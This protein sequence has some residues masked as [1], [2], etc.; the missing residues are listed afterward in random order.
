MGYANDS[1]Y[2]PATIASIMDSLMA[3]LNTQFETAYTTDSFIGTNWYK[4][5]Y[6]AAQRIQQD[7]TKT[8]EI[9]ANLQ[10][11]FKITNERIQRPVATSPGI[12]E[13]L[14]DAGYIAS[15]KPIISADAGKMNICVSTDETAPTYA[16][17][18]L[19]INTLISESVAGGIVTV[20]TE[21]STIVLSNG[22]S[23]AFVFHLPNRITPK[24]RLT[25]TL[26]ENNQVLV[27]DPDD[28]KA[29]L[30]A[31]IAAKYRLGLDFAPQKYFTTVDAPWT[32]QV[33]LEYSLDGGSTYVSTIYTANFDDLFVIDLANV[34][35][36]E[37]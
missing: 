36:V 32:S 8:S 14:Q 37:E 26:S 21:S 35:L 7:E 31:N 34:E 10:Q 30:I 2:T 22:Q 29:L 15:V 12:I 3:D 27:G 24:I 18:K 20:G 17:T 11:Y 25:T 4:Y 33:L 19:A 28:T 16:A 9:F 23:F 13:A 5:F 1:G 6:A